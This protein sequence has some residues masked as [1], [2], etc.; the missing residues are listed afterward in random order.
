MRSGVDV[1]ILVVALEERCRSVDDDQI[2]T[3][4]LFQLLGDGCVGSADGEGAIGK[5][6]VLVART[7][8]VGLAGQ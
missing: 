5:M 3:T 8:A 6:N 1:V 7:D 4:D 2:S